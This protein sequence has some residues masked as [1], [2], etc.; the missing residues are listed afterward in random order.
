MG[1]FKTRL[2][3]FPVI[4]SL[5]YHINAN[6]T[7]RGSAGTLRDKPESTKSYFIVKG[8]RKV[9]R[10]KTAFGFAKER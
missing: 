6:I 3:M 1:V 7:I 9:M 8:I 4:P 10:K 2:S 5:K